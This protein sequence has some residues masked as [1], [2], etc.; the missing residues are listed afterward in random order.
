MR[1]VLPA[2]LAI[3]AVLAASVAEARPKRVVVIHGRSFLDSGRQ[4]PVGS[5]QSYTTQSTTLNQPVY[6]SFQRDG[7]GNDVLPGR[8]GGIGR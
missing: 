5:L 8:F 4:V 6:L 1:I 2:A 3:A 7:F